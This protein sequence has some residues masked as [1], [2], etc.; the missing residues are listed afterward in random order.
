MQ[1][2][3]EYFNIRLKNNKN[4]NK[5]NINN[6][7]SIFL[8]EELFVDEYDFPCNNLVCQKLILYFFI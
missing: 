6:N 2:Q 4:F 1:N 8:N 3:H 5:H 7:I